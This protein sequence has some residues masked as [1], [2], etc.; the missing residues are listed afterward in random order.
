MIKIMQ[1]KCSTFDACI[2]MIKIMQYTYD[3]MIM[4]RQQK[5]SIPLIPVSL[6]KDKAVEMQPIGS[7]KAAYVIVCH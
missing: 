3:M 6:N 7:T 2:L 5:C 1:Y 4:I